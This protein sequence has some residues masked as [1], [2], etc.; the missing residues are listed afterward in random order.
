MVKYIA[1]IRRK[2]GISRDD[3]LRHWREVHGPMFLE[4][5]PPDLRKYVQNHP[6]E[7]PGIEVE[8]DVD[9]VVE[10][11]F[12]NVEALQNWIKHW[13]TPPISSPGAQKLMDD[14][15]DYFDVSR[16]IVVVTEEHII[17]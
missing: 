17:K 13:Q 15:D 8:S 11:Y 9:G 4:F 6:I 7:A 10:I 3:F 2:P 16:G 1:M 12:D 5:G 14:L